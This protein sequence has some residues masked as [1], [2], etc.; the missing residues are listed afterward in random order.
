MNN[1]LR[2]VDTARK[3]EI[4]AYEVLKDFVFYDKITYIGDD[5]QNGLADIFT[6]DYTIGV[7]VISCERRVVHKFTERNKLPVKFSMKIKSDKLVEKSKDKLSNVTMPQEE[8]YHNLKV[9]ITKK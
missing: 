7:E 2:I 1:L 9:G 5:V 6:D 4:F 3:E 8:F